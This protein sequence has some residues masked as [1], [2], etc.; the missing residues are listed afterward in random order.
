MEPS[1]EILMFALSITVCL[2][3]P[4]ERHAFLNQLGRLKAFEERRQGRWVSA[5]DECSFREEEWY[6]ELE[7]ACAASEERKLWALRNIREWME[8]LHS[9]LSVDVHNKVEMTKAVSK[10]RDG[11]FLLQDPARSSIREGDL[12]KKSTRTGRT[13]E[14]RFFLF[15]DVLLYANLDARWQLYHSRRAAASSNEGR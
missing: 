3:M 15:S 8:S 7:E 1:V 4:M 10:L 12:L 11:D 2:D 5:P 6:L 9:A 14:Y 13:T